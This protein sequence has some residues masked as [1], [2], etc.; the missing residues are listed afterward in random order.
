MLSLSL[1]LSLKVMMFSWWLSTSWVM[2][3]VWSTPMTPLPSW[4]PSTSGLIPKTSSSQTTTAEASR[5]SMVGCSPQGIGNLLHIF[6]CSSYNIHNT[7][8][9][10]GSSQ[11]T[12]VLCRT[13]THCQYYEML[14]EF[15]G[16]FTIFPIF[17]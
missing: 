1:S 3:W 2:L 13:F 15:P 8:T 17:V 14:H 7:F 10:H 4:P 5:Q 12:Q 11:E 6:A 16:M 9:P